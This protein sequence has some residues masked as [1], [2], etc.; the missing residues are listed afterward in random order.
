MHSSRRASCGAGATSRT[1]ACSRWNSPTRASSCS[2]GG[3]AHV[4]GFDVVRDPLEVR[5]RIG[6]AAQD[7]TVDELL[8][9]RENLVMI[10]ELHH[11]PRKAARTRAQELLE[12]FDLIDAGDRLARDYSGG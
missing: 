8:T 1:A 3:A 7:A 12:R 11:L 5:R 10:G 6:L 9:G 2:T 4:A